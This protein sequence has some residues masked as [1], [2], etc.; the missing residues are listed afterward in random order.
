MNQT[1]D[2]AWV[3][4]AQSALETLNPLEARIVRRALGI[5]TGKV[6]GSAE[7]GAGL[8]IPA[9]FVDEY[10]RRAL[11]KLRHPSRASALRE[12]AGVHSAVLLDLLDGAPAGVADRVSPPTEAER[13]DR[14]AGVLPDPVVGTAGFLEAALR[15]LEDL[16]R[17]VE[18]A[19]A[20]VVPKCVTEIELLTP[21]LLDHLRSKGNDLEKLRPEVF[22]HVVAELLAS[23]KFHGVK[24]LGRDT[25]TAAD[26]FAA[27]FVDDVGEHRYFIEVKRWK[28]RIGVEVIDRVYGARLLEQPRFG[29]T[30]AM[31]V[32]IYGFKDFR[33]YSRDDLRNMGMFLKDRDDLLNWLEDYAPNGNGLWVPPEWPKIRKSATSPVPDRES[34]ETN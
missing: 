30:A 23:R 22:E 19:A 9:E 29:W 33:K 16:A 15:A 4:A 7:I 1:Y 8:R 26:I 24:L 28:D 12:L 34:A 27:K 5:L 3:K 2:E 31:V 32:S 21:E 6:A 10:Q 11:R 25:A 14:R 18:R 17:R 20:I 13:S